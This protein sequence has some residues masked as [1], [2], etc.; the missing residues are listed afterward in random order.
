LSG[1]ADSN[2]LAPRFLSEEGPLVNFLIV[3]TQRGGTTS[4]AH[5]LAA[6]PEICFAERKEIHFF[7]S[8]DEFPGG[9]SSPEARAA[10]HAAFANYA[11]ERHVGEASPTYMYVPCAS[12]RIRQYN[13]DMKLIFL[14]RD[15]GVRAES[16][17]WHERSL[18]RERLPKA[19]A[20]ALEAWRLRCDR[21]DWSDR[22]SQRRHSYIDRGH[23]ETQIRRM[24]EDFPRDQML[25][26]RSERLFEAHA[27]SL[28]EVCAFLG[29]DPPDP[30]PEA[31]HLNSSSGSG[32][33]RARGVERATR[34]WLKSTRAL[35]ALLG[36]D[37]TDWKR[38]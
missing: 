35:E 27:E 31:V 38:V 14:L 3:G 29:V 30:F 13:P 9:W 19:I 37:L 6:H 22:S 7:D 21:K 5:Y 25:F 18:K 34:A 2:H 26:L 20:F 23:Y 33:D 16:Q 1:S 4:L 15:P 12:P 8:V 24:L 32:S 10:Y 11:G 28:K 36:W 17:Y